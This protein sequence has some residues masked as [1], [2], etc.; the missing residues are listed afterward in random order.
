MPYDCLPLTDQLRLYLVRDES[1]LYSSRS[2]RLFGL[3]R[4]AT[5]TLLRLSAGEAL[6]DAADPAVPDLAALLAGDEPAAEAYRPQWFCPPEPPVSLPLQPCYRLLTTTF[7]LV[8]DDPDRLAGLHRLI[9]HL[10]LPVPAVPDLLFEVQRESG[11]VRLTMNGVPQGDA[12]PVGML[13]PLLLDRLRKHAYQ[14]L[15]YL[16]AMHAAVVRW[17]DRTVILPGQS[18]SGKSTLAAALLARGGQLFSDEVALVAADGF[19][20]PI[21]LPPGLKS[22][23]WAPLQG[24]FPALAAGDEHLRWDDLRIRYLPT[25]AIRF[26]PRPERASHLVF[27]RFLPGAAAT[28]DRLSPVQALRRLADA[29]FQVCGLDAERVESIVAWLSG[30]SALSLT[31]ASTGEAVQALAREIERREGAGGGV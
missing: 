16:L 11:Q 2:R 10:A 4:A 25:E 1:L 5:V 19:L 14:R 6:P 12:G 17:R 8:C 24:D 7:G 18:G 29:G 23:S 31:Y 13:A 26:A 27:P 21:P 9:A 15:P 30:L 28:A 22:G 20:V 3:D